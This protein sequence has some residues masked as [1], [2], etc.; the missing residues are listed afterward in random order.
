MYEHANSER[1]RPERMLLCKFSGSR[2]SQYAGLLCA[3]SACA[4]I[5]KP[6]VDGSVLCAS[7]A[8]TYPRSICRTGRA[9]SCA[10]ASQLGFVAKP[11]GSP[12]GGKTLRKRPP[13]VPEPGPPG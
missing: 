10:C 9:I 6:V 3:E 4:V 5:V 8:P 11:N 2:S 13:P 7:Y 1:T 12:P